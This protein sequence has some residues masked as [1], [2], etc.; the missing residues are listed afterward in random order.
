MDLIILHCLHLMLT[1]K[2]LGLS[3]DKI[4]EFKDVIDDK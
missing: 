2:F 1:N 3:H 4:V